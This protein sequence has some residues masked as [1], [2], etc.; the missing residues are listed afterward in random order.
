MACRHRSFFL[1]SRCRASAMLLGDRAALGEN[2]SLGGRL[3]LTRGSIRKLQSSTF[4][5]KAA[6]K[7][8]AKVAI[9]DVDR[10][11]NADNVHRTFRL[12]VCQIRAFGLEG[13]PQCLW[14]VTPKAGHRADGDSG[15]NR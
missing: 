4:S 13:K 1:R 2:S 6:V 14:S 3:G 7:W 10:Y 12:R 5:C 8:S 9:G 11:A 15:R